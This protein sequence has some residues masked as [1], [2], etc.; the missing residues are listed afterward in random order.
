MSENAEKTPPEQLPENSLEP[1]DEHPHQ[2]SKHPHPL[3]LT[4]ALHRQ[5]WGKPSRVVLPQA[6]TA[7]GE[8]AA[9]SFLEYFVANIRNPN[10]RGAYFRA[11]VTFFRWGSQLRCCHVVDCSGKIYTDKMTLPHR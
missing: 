8:H 4:D 9:K 7:A 2:P 10:T 11:V 3:Q 5:A 1:H 6:I